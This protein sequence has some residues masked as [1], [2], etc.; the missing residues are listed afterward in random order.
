MCVCV[1]VCVFVCV[2]V[3]VHVCVCARVCVC[4][5]ARALVRERQ[6]DGERMWREDVVLREPVDTGWRRLIGSLIF[7]GHFLQK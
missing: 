2:C 5:C 1:C 3:C 4:V 6:K 7:I